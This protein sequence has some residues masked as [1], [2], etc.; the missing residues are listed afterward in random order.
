[1]SRYV[2]TAIAVWSKA[3]LWARAPAVPPCGDCLKFLQFHGFRDSAVVDGLRHSCPI[4]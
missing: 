1:M 2:P 4:T 3:L